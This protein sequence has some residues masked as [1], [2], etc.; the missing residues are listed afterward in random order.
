MKKKVYDVCFWVALGMGLLFLNYPLPETWAGNVA[1]SRVQPQ[2][3]DAADHDSVVAAMQAGFDAVLREKQTEG[4]EQKSRL[5][6]AERRSAGLLQIIAALVAVIAVFL[7]LSLNLLYRK[8]RHARQRRNERNLKQYQS[9]RDP[10]TGLPNRRAFYESIKKRGKFDNRRNT[11]SDTAPQALILLDIDH[12]KLI[13]DT[14]GH[15]VGDI[16]LV[17]VSQRLSGMMREDDRLMR[18]GAAE[19]LLI[20]N[21][22]ARDGIEEIVQRV[23][24]V[25]A[26]NGISAVTQHLNVTASLGYILLNQHGCVDADLERSLHLADAALYKAKIAGRNRAL[27]VQI[28][29][30]ESQEPA[31]CPD[32]VWMS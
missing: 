24:E 6:A 12:F 15:A 20:L 23:L 8:A 9:R 25:V 21:N 29:D 5:E 16:V 13:N 3:E 14:L 18:W 22:V 4:Q 28:P 26:A 30:M 27:G 7:A 31:R 1:G 10:L 19:F 11:G 17:E 32:L 2:V